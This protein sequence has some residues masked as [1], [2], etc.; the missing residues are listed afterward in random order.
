MD[1]QIT[2]IGQVLAIWAVPLVLIGAAL[3]YFHAHWAIWV[4][5]ALWII[6][7]LAALVLGQDEDRRENLIN[8]LSD[9]TYRQAYTAT[10]EHPTDKLWERYVGP[11]PP[12]GAWLFP[13]ALTWQTY[14]VALRIAVAYPV[15]LLIG[16][17]LLWGGD[18]ALNGAALQ[19][20][21]AEWWHIWPERAALLGAF[22]L[23]ILAFLIPRLASAS[24]QRV[25]EN[26]ADWLQIGAVAVAFALAVAGAGAFAFAFAGAFAVAVAG[27]GAFAVAGAGAG[28]FA[29][30]GAGAGAGAFALAFALAFAVAFA[31]AFAFAL[32]V[33]VIWLDAKQ[34]HRLA[35]VVLTCFI[36][37]GWIAL[38]QFGDL[39]AIPAEGQMIFLFLGV[40]PLINALFDTVSY[41]ATL[42]LVGWG[43]RSPLRVAGVIAG[44]LDL[45]IAAVLF[46]GLT[47]TLTAVVAGLNRLSGAS[48]LDLNVLFADLDANLWSHPWVPLMIA[49]TLLPTALHFGASLLALQSFTPLRGLAVGQLQRMDNDIMAQFVAPL[50]AGFCL[51]F[52][53]ILGGLALWGLIALAM[54]GLSVAG[55]WYLDQLLT[56][57]AVISGP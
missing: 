48:L 29:V 9:P 3:P 20:G 8:L 4:G 22:A 15:F 13:A 2:R 51:A 27:A 17:W 56:I 53:L 37:L 30:A 49:S 45:V 24:Q 25:S 35:R 47:L 52:P 23:L 21:T 26:V 44:L 57:A 31:V 16:P 14:D 11:T 19:A 10:V 41:A 46:A 7:A 18:V 38:A 1:K 39:A 32:A 12:D 28:A 5:V 34:R 43:I 40:F 55:G 42:A 6:C 50:V 36:P 33:A 54:P